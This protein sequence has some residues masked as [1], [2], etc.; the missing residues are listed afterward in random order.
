MRNQGDYIRDAFGKA[1][2]HLSERQVEQFLFYYEMLIAKNRVMNLT[3][4]VGF[5]EVVLKHFLDSLMLCRVVTPCPAGKL[6]DVGTG[7]GFP[8]IPLK[9]MYPELEVVLLDSLNK[10]VRFLDEVI[11]ELGLEKI[12]TI[13]GRAEDFARKEE[14]REEFDLCVSRAVANLASLAEYCI[15]FVRLGGSFVAYKGGKVVEELKMGERAIEVLGG[16]I[17]EREEFLIPGSDL[18]RGLLKVEKVE[19]TPLKYPRKA[20]VPRKEPIC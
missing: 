5:E 12:R 9:I 15:P 20:G 4:I 13:H 11:K 1:S 8:G 2:L 19:K 3:A 10:R 7:A 17:V 6:I 18:F 14:Y 16:K